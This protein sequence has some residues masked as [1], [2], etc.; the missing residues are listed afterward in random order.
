MYNHLEIKTALN[1]TFSQPYSYV[2]TDST[3]DSLR[4]DS[5]MK[6]NEAYEIRYEFWP[7]DHESITVKTLGGVAA[8]LKKYHCY[9]IRTYIDPKSNKMIFTIKESRQRA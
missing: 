2:D 8:Y 3:H 5:T 6:N 7:A 9:I 4:K 1:K